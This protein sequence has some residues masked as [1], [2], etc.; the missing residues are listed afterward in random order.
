MKV[1]HHGISRLRFGQF[2]VDLLEGKLF[3]RGVP[4]RIENQPFQ[5][6]VALL[7]R[8]GEVVD[9]EEL[10]SRLW[11][12]G[13]YVDFDEGVNTA[14]SKLRYALH[15]SAET[16]V[17]V[18][19][20]PRRGYRFLAPISDVTTIEAASADIGHAAAP[21][22]VPPD[23]VSLA[24]IEEASDSLGR[25]PVVSSFRRWWAAGLIGLSVLLAIGGWAVYR[26]RV[27]ASQAVNRE[28]MQIRKLADT[29]I[30]EQITISPDGRYVV[31]ARRIGEK[32]SL[33]MRQ[34]E[35]GGDVEVLSP[36]D[37]DFVGL[38]F[39]PDGSYLYYL[40]SEIEDHGLKH[41]YVMPAL[42]GP[43][44]KL[45]PNVDSPVS[46]SPDGRQFVVT[47]GIPMKNEVEIRIAN[48][49]GSGEHLLTTMQE[50]DAGYQPGATWSPD[51]RT[52]VVPV[53]SRGKMPRS[54]LYAISLPEGSQRELYSNVG[55]VGRSV[56][57]PDGS[58][59]LATLFEQ[60]DRRGQLW[61]ISF[62]VGKKERI[63][64]DL[65]DY[66]TTLDITPDGKSAVTAGWSMV[67]NIWAAPA[68]DRSRLE[69]IT[70]GDT[71]MF[72]AIETN[73]GK[74]LVAGGGELW[75]M[76]ANGS[77]RAS[78]AKL[79]GH[80][81]RTCGTFVIAEVRQDGQQ[82]IVRLNAD[83]SHA[84][85]LAEGTV[86]SPVCSPDEKF[87]FYANVSP[88]QRIL[89]V[90]I[91]GGTPLEI[92]R[93]PGDGLMGTVDI[94]NDGKY[95][96]FKWEQYKPV[97]GMHLSV[98]S[99]SDG[100]QVKSMMVPTEL[101]CLRWSADDK[102]LQYA[103]TRDGVDNIWQQ[104]LSGGPPKQLTKFTSGLIFK[105][106]RAKSDGRLLM[107]RGRVTADG[108]LLTHLR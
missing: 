41:L 78:F 58:A 70:S 108:V 53:I 71:A 86:G 51:G 92:A 36:D 100:S 106:S 46:F 104:P 7:E 57:L 101:R 23:T 60:N 62:P 29:S 13:T 97:P 89:R 64:N 67:S 31:Y 37:T 63:T 9:R 22:A 102:A 17:F 90:P 50:S 82:H 77:A 87:V 2:E 54:A 11:P 5:I 40:R 21:P 4:V 103:L 24:E 39:S 105:F 48:R 52:I 98:I 55:F 8:P 3:H 43:S 68:A 27:L 93:I 85:S 75:I 25:S 19:T 35:S 79:D 66:S 59:L 44:R 99:S 76:N 38:T 28:T 81:I 84:T 32:S 1:S 45:V 65:S 20:V 74:L 47:R 91:E 12:S 30:V 96:A 73:D 6:L 69:Q 83:G 16:P 14:I 72:E 56:W 107:A 10:R 33:R 18:E 26:W 88:F 80:Q 15:D 94:S 95:L 61:T 34:L 42:G 49:D